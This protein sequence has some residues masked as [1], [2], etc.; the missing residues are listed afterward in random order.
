MARITPPD[1]ATWAR[2]EDVLRLVE[3]RG[4][5]IAGEQGV[6][7]M[8]EHN[9]AGSGRG[10]KVPYVTFRAV[11]ELEADAFVDDELDS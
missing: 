3:E 4:L 2:L 6:R 5:E 8:V 10:G 11:G 9:R 1:P 7:V